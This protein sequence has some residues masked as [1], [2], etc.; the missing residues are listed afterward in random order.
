MEKAGREP[1]EAKIL[2]FG[3]VPEAGKLEYYAS[4]GI[5]EVVLRIPST[6]RDAVLP[7]LDEYAKWV[8]RG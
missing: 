6:P 8:K 4:I 2:P 3:T 1:S 7:V 5:E